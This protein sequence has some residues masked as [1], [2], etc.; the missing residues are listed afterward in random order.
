MINENS[1]IIN[2]CE[3]QLIEISATSKIGCTCEICGS[4][5]DINRHICDLCRENLLEIITWWKVKK[6]YV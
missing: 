6:K 1:S 4:P 2:L 3:T 5:T